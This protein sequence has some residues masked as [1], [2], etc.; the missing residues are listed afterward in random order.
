MTKIYTDKV[1]KKLKN[2]WNHM[3]FHPTN[4]IEDD[5]GKQQ[6][7]KLSEDKAVQIVR[8]YSMFEESVT[9]GED[10]QMQYDFSMNDHRIDYLLSKGFTPYI[11]YAF[12]P[13]FLSA[14][15]D[16]EL[17]GRR[18]KG[19]LLYRSYVNDYSKWEEI[20]RV[21]TKHLVDRYGE[22][23]V[24]KWYIHCYNEPDSSH[25]FYRT[26][27]TWEDRAEAYCKL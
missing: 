15:Q 18:Y 20:C 1:E 26:A 27:P 11:A 7:D 17:I 3:V 22:D 2:F 10:G 19:N 9:L 24:A 4:A 13:G 21:Y 12:F 8:I 23:T 25:F 16:D 5:W 14:E 6:L